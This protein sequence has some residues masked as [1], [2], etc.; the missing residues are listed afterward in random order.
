MAWNPGNSILENYEDIDM[1]KN[2]SKVFRNLAPLSLPDP[3]KWIIKYDEKETDTQELK[4]NKNKNNQNKT[5]KKKDEFKE[6]NAK[7]ILEKTIKKELVQIENI[8]NPIYLKV[9][10]EEGNLAKSI[11]CMEL[12]YNQNKKKSYLDVWLSYSNIYEKLRKE[13]KEDKN[14]KEIMNKIYRKNKKIISDIKKE[15]EKIE[16]ITR[17]QLDEMSYY[18]PPLDYLSY[19]N[20]EFILDNWQKQAIEW[21]DE[22]KSILLCAPTS[23]GKTFLT[24]YLIKNTDRILFIVP[25]L[26]LAL[27]VSAMFYQLGTGSVWILDEDF[28]YKS[29]NNPKIIIGTPNDILRRID[30]IDI[31]TISSL[32]IDEI[33]EININSS[34]EML[35]HIILNQPQQVQFLGLSATIG[36]PEE[37]KNWLSYF[38]EDIELIYVNQRFFN[39]SRYIYHQQNVTQLTPLHTLNIQDIIE[40]NNIDY[41]F[42]PKNCLY[43]ADKMYEYGFKFDTPTQYFDTNKRIELKETKQYA[44]YLIDV[45]KKQ[46][47]TDIQKFITNIQENTNLNSTQIGNTKEINENKDNIYD[48]CIYLTQHELTPTILFHLDTIQLKKYFDQ[49]QQIFIQKEKET[50]PNYQTIQQKKMDKYLET[51]KEREK[52]LSKITNENKK[53]EWERDHPE[54]NCPDS[55]G[56]PH[57]DFVLKTKTENISIQDIKE[58]KDKLYKEFVDKNME[59]QIPKLLELFSA[60]LRGFAIYTQDLPTLYLR[61]VQQLT[62]QGKISILLSDKSLAFGINMPIKTVCF[63]QDTPLLNTLMYQQMEGRCGRRGLDKNGNVFFCGFTQTRIKELVNGKVIPIQGNQDIIN[64]NIDIIPENIYNK[65]KIINSIKTH[66]LSKLEYNQNIIQKYQNEVDN[67]TTTELPL[68]WKLS[69]YKNAYHICM[70]MKW[71]KPNKILHLRNNENDDVLFFSLI[72]SVIEID[73]TDNKENQIDYHKLF[74][75]YPNKLVIRTLPDYLNKIG[76]NYDM[77]QLENYLYRIFQFNSIP[78]EYKKD[79]NLFNKIKNK[80]KNANMIMLILRNYYRKTSMEAIL[81]KVWRRLYW[82]SKTISIY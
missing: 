38:I 59:N 57:P 35:I 11:K 22:K 39:L 30:E 76:I 52:T 81:R 46:N 53:L 72:S 37:F 26:P 24:T 41:P 48:L 4:N 56:S 34:V 15:Y 70:F 80:L 10:T 60:L 29:S 14:Q 23:S 47:K 19:Y 77:Y 8:D 63:Y 74:E 75:K 18:L 55:V 66:N 1:K 44:N 25:T 9:T 2:P 73:I 31:T 28:T 5:K 54:P 32:V 17:Y 27:Q 12:F 7:K 20:K 49:L 36:N 71:I 58:V 78:P 6:K 61:C 16:D 45:L 62:Q 67:L 43:M 3:S 51:M 69:K 21:I 33:H 68:Y 42:T 50:Y 13:Y 79:I 64:I 65:D 40:N 82:I